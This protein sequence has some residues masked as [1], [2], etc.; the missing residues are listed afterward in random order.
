MRSENLDRWESEREL[1]AGSCLVSTMRRAS[2]LERQGV[3]KTK[4]FLIRGSPRGK[5]A[6][7]V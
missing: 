2:Q 4:R 1:A 7:K 5:H 3:Q 6:A